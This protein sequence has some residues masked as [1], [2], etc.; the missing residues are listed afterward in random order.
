MIDVKIVVRVF[1]DIF[2]FGA[3]N[4]DADI[5]P[6]LIADFKPERLLQR[7]RNGAGEQIVLSRFQLPDGIR[8]HG[9]FFLFHDSFHRDGKIDHKP[10]PREFGNPLQLSV[11]DRFQG[12]DHLIE[13]FRVQQG[14]D[15]YFLSRFPVRAGGGFPEFVTADI[16]INKLGKSPA[17]GFLGAFQSDTV[18][19]PPGQLQIIFTEPA[20]NGVHVVADGPFTDFEQIRIVVQLLYAFIFEDFQNQAFSSVFLIH[21]FR[22]L[23]TEQR[24]GKGFLVFFVALQTDAYP[25]LRV[26]PQMKGAQKGIYI[27]HV[28]EKRTLAGVQQGSKFAD[29]N[30]LRIFQ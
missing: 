21:G 5:R 2:L 20:G 6:F 26:D 25:G 3:F 10:D 23:V 11:R 9:D 29:G 17:V 24:L 30:G 28:A 8:F 16:F 4:M 27:F 22:F 7:V 1:V 14:I 19:L 12:G 13:N 15:V 18:S